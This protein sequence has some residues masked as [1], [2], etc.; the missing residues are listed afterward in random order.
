[1][2]KKAKQLILNGKEIYPKTIASGVDCGGETLEDV[3]AR[4]N[5]SEDALV[6]TLRSHFL[7]KEGAD[8]AV[9]PIIINNGLTVNGGVSADDIA[10]S[11]SLSLGGD[12]V[13][14]KNSRGESVLNVDRL[15]VAVRALFKELTIEK[16]SHVGGAI[17]VSPASGKAKAVAV[18]GNTIKITLD[19]GEYNSSTGAF[20]KE[21]LFKLGDFVRCQSWGSTQRFWWRGVVG[22]GT[23]YILVSN[24]SD[25]YEQGVAEDSDIPAVGDEFA[26][27][28]NGSDTDRQNVII[29]DSF[30]DD[31]PSIKQY[32][33]VS[34]MALTS[35]RLVTRLSPTGNYFR[36]RFVLE[37]GT[38]VGGEGSIADGWRLV[39]SPT[40]LY[41]PVN[42]SGGVV[43]PEPTTTLTIWRNGEQVDLGTATG[44]RFSPAAADITS[45]VFGYEQ[46]DGISITQLGNVLKP[47][48]I[49]SDV[50]VIKVWADITLVNEESFTIV[51]YLRLTKVTGEVVSGR[52]GQNAVVYSI[53]PAYNVVKREWQ[54]RGD[55]GEWIKVHTP[56]RLEVYAYRTEGDA[57]TSVTGNLW[58][59]RKRKNVAESGYSPFAGSVSITD[60]TEYIAFQLRIN[61]QARAQTIVPVIDCTTGNTVSN[62]FVVTKEGLFSEFNESFDMIRGSISTLQQ[63]AENIRASVTAITGDETQTG[64]IEVAAGNVKAEVIAG[65]KAAGINLNGKDSTITLTADHTVVSDD[66]VVKKLKT[67]DSGARVEI[68]D[69]TIKV[70]GSNGRANIVF[71]TDANGNAVLQYF[72][73]GGNV[74]SVF[75]GRGFTSRVAQSEKVVLSTDWFKI[76]DD[77]IADWDM[78]TTLIFN[79]EKTHYIADNLQNTPTYVYTAAR[80]NGNVLAGSFASVAQATAADGAYFETYQ[81]GAVN[82][83][84]SNVW[85]A[86]GEPVAYHDNVAPNSGQEDYEGYQHF[87]EGVDFNRSVVYRVAVLFD[88]GKVVGKAKLYLNK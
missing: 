76:P 36:G 80:T 4:L 27:V 45:I 5:I 26:V 10:A 40:D 24:D 82:N 53:E 42:N 85:L 32:A 61:N 64:A 19:L 13:L 54:F 3:L 78:L 28:G 56:S 72:D 12:V 31:A 70:F 8:T 73:A 37:D 25:N 59:A 60:D 52:D 49:A 51:E 83:A 23:D 9:G 18:Q 38:E 21:N 68:E 11:D 29:I 71:G 84:L 67:H 30:G 2:A 46:A 6:N 50:A 57:R 69:T 55:T 43:S 7:S 17:I 35:E 20:E 77:T 33:G 65:L 48:A 41:C 62:A 1:M 86:A 63:T 75:D 16:E 88:G 87:Y 34:T 58:Y 81:N 74:V 14:M 66:L 79:G 22:V 15:N 44:N 39:L 47:T